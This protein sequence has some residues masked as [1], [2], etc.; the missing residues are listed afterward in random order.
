MNKKA[1]DDSNEIK[2]KSI[3]KKKGKTKIRM[4]S[5]FHD[6]NYEEPPPT[7][8]DDGNQKEDQKANPNSKS[9]IP[10]P[11]YMKYNPK[12]GTY[13]RS[14]PPNATLKSMAEIFPNKK[15]K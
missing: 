3:P 13:F 5:K 4:A 12:Y 6:K 14:D 1:D 2:V 9:K 15:V 7:E 11:Y 10:L 8:E